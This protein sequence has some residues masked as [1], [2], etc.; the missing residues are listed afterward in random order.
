MLFAKYDIDQNR[1]LD[2]KELHAM[3]EDLEGKKKSIE[4]E[5]EENKN[6]RRDSLISLAHGARHLPPQFDFGKISKRVDRMEY[7]LATISNKIDSLFAN[8]I[9]N[10]N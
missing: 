10:D 6:K 3:F 7:V 5:M 9:E 2:E 4:K 8:R 1:E